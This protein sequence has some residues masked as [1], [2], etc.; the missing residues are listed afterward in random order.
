[1]RTKMKKLTFGCLLLCLT[2]ATL[3][4]IRI[5]RCPTDGYTN[6]AAEAESKGCK[7]VEGGNVTIVDGTRL[8]IRPARI[9]ATP[10]ETKQFRETLKVG[11]YS[12]AGLVVEVKSPVVKV[13]TDR[14]ERW[15]RIDELE[16]P[17]KPALRKK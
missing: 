12:N 1:M 13:Q 3:G 16:A 4:E 11:D 7:V 15:Y 17:S 8:P 10:A 6:N 2:S 14:G 5:Y 9:P